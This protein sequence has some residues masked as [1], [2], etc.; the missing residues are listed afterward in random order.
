V[1]GAGWSRLVHP[2]PGPDPDAR[3]RSCREDGKLWIAP[4]RE[5]LLLSPPSR[6]MQWKH[7]EHQKPQ[8]HRYRDMMTSTDGPNRCSFNSAGNLHHR[9]EVIPENGMS[10]STC[11]PR[12]AE[13]PTSNPELFTDMNHTWFGSESCFEVLLHSMNRRSLT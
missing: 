6:H 5:I 8:G 1:T 7:L 12:H 9:T 10:R 11:V 13:F 4:I 2:F 3:P